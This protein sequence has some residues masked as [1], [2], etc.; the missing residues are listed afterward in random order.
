M[1]TD[2]LNS[3][4]DKFPD[5]PDD[6]QTFVDRDENNWVYDLQTGSWEFSGPKLNLDLASED[7]TG[8]LSPR[9]KLLLDTVA[10]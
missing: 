1:A 10:L 4:L 7:N 9:F 3:E 8:L 5:N 2:G 6:K